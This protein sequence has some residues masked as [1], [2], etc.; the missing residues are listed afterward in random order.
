MLAR[1][2]HKVGFV[3]ACCVVSVSRGSP[4]LHNVTLN[5][6]NIDSPYVTVTDPGTGVVF[7]NAKTNG[8]GDFNID[9]FNATSSLPDI[10]PGRILSAEGFVGNG[11]VSAPTNFGFT[12]TLPTPSRGVS[13]IMDYVFDGDPTTSVSLQGFDAQG[14]L[15][16]ADNLNLPYVSFQEQALSLSSSTDNIVTVT[17]T[18]TGISDNFGAITYTTALPEPTGLL[19]MAA[20]CLLLLRRSRGAAAI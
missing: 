11:G 8:G 20:G 9:Y 17:L 4:V 14:N 16:S 19:G 7:S 13:M 18:P 15:V 3:L 1:W 6:L 10:T 2:T 12:M 5:G